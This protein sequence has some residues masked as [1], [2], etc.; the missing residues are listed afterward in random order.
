[1]DSESP[2]SRRTPHWLWWP[3][4]YLTVFFL[5]VAL[6]LAGMTLY[7]MIQVRNHY[8]EGNEAIRLLLDPPADHEEV[9]DANH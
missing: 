4:E 5:F 8:E 6:V 7:L 2:T 9:S 3:W 1:M